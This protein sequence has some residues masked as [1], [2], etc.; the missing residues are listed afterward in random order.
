MRQQHG[1]GWVDGDENRGHAAG[2][3]GEGGDDGGHGNGRSDHP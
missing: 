1:D 2:K 3:V